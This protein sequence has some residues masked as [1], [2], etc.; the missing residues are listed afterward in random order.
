MRMRFK[1]HFSIA[2]L[3]AAA[4]ADDWDAQ[5]DLAVSA[6]KLGNLEGRRGR[7]RGCSAGL[8]GKRVPILRKLAGKDNDPWAPNYLSVVLERIGDIERH[9]GKKTAAREHYEESLAIARRLAQAQPE[10]LKP[11]LDV[12]SSLTHVA[13]VSESPLGYYQEALDIVL[14]LDRAGRLRPED[15]P[16]IAQMRAA[17]AEASAAPAAPTAPASPAAGA[18]P[19]PASQAPLPPTA[20]PGTGAAGPPASWSSRLRGW[21]AGK[22]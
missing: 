4:R 10:S 17:V 11:A 9:A 14:T 3:L 5:R 15:R 7:L 21:F 13:A 2:R 19:P 12:V 18:P 6:N 8:S 1:P 22:E 16:Y 20:A